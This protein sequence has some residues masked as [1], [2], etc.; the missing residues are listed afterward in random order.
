MR[1]ISRFA[2]YI[3]LL[4]A[5]IM[6]VVLVILLIGRT[7]KTIEAP[8]MIALM[9]YVNVASEIS[10]IIR[11][12]QVQEGDAVKTGDTIFLIGA[13]DLEF[14][15]ERSRLAEAEARA[16]L[17]KLEEEYRNLTA[18]ESFE[19]IAVLADLA[20]AQKRMEFAGAQY[21]RADS[22]A[23]RGLLS[24]EDRDRAKLEYELQES[25]Y[26][27]LQQRLTMLESRYRRQIEDQQNR[28]E[29]AERAYCLVQ[30]KLAKTV[31][32]SPISGTVLTPQIDQLIGTKAVEGQ[33][34]VRIGNLSQLKFVARVS[35]NDIP[36]VQIGQEV[37]VFVNAFPHHLYKC[38]AGKVAKIPSAAEATEIGVTFPTD[39]ELQELWVETAESR[40]YLKPG[41]SGR[42]E[43]VIK[44]NV[45]LIKMILDGIAK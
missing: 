31:I 42:A 45:G 40:F 25:Y 38:F 21:G 14:E 17:A 6:A 32:T 18:S 8:G 28:V 12:F 7:D 19:T 37:K 5:F 9:D 33:P 22:L 29:L 11:D 36:E 23:K 10:G 39:I 3:F 4:V 13:G 30:Q 24:E 15:V 20:A 16:G 27:V 44:K 34:V 41:M 2:T 35:E 43:I 1:R 26:R